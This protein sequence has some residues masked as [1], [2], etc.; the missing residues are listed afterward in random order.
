MK[1][2]SNTYNSRYLLLRKEL[3]KPA[4]FN[5]TTTMIIVATVLQGLVEAL[6]YERPEPCSRS[7]VAKVLCEMSGVMVIR[8]DGVAA[9]KLG[10]D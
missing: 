2:Q 3:V 5:N 8:L 1:C 10:V 9:I 7:K 4:A 6:V